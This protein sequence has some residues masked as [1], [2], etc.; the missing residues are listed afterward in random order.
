MK[1]RVSLAFVIL[2]YE[3]YACIPFAVGFEK[4]TCIKDKKLSKNAGRYCT[5]ILIMS[6]THSPSRIVW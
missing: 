1:V 3:R 4:C 2:L 5:G 6:L